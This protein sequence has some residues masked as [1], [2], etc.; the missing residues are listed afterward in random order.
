MLTRRQIIKSSA[1]AGLGLLPMPP[2]CSPAE[3]MDSNVAG[4]DLP[5]IN[6]QYLANGALFAASPTTLYVAVNNNAPLRP[7]YGGT[8]NV[9]FSF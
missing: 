6:A 4:F 3:A 9:S 5:G 8:A 2:W 1:F 7:A